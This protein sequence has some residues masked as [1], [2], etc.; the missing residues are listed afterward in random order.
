VGAFNS[1]WSKAETFIITAPPPV[2]QSPAPASRPNAQ[3]ATNGIIAAPPPVVQPPAPVSR[4]NAQ[5]AKGRFDGNW[6]EE[7]ALVGPEYKPQNP[8]QP[9]QLLAFE[10]KKFRLVW[11]PFEVYYDYWGT[12]TCDQ[13]KGRIEFKI[14]YGNFIPKDFA[15]K[16]TY[17]FD[18]R[19]RLV[20]KGVW[21]GTPRN[22]QATGDFQGHIFVNRLSLRTSSLHE[23]AANG[24]TKALQELIARGEDVNQ[25]DEREMTPLHLAASRGRKLAVKLLLSGGAEVDARGGGL[26]ALDM[27]ALAG[28]AEIAE[29]LIEAGA[30]FG[31]KN[32]S[33]HSPLQLMLS[34]SF[35]HW[36]PGAGGVPSDDDIL[37]TVELFINRGADLHDNTLLPLAAANSST[38]VVNLLLRRGVD[39]NCRD[40][41]RLHSLAS[42]CSQK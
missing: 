9:I 40:K 30:D 37:K 5:A 17:S 36:V 24:N 19:G 12:Y 13:A 25:M 33:G 7:K 34:G 31:A 28:R 21:F 10:G 20:L 26:T 18:D 6:R 41:R 4:P 39:V 15:G 14:E 11:H 29:L 3:A 16:G 2:I 32:S 23:A 1:E 38:N 27:A 42:G 22:V 8:Q 35:S